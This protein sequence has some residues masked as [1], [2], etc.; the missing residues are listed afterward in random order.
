MQNKN[1]NKNTNITPSFLGGDEFNS[2]DVHVDGER[3]SRRAAA[4]SANFLAI[5]Y[6]NRITEVTRFKIAKGQ[7]DTWLLRTFDSINQV[8][9]GVT[10]IVLL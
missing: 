2:L 3:T 4:E 9:D 5:Q 6:C 7:A 8:T 1:K 10:L